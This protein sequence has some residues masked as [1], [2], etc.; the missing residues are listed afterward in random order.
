MACV[1]EEM[2][3]MGLEEELSCPICLELYQDPVSLPC[4][5]NFCRECL[6]IHIQQHRDT[7]TAEGTQFHCPSCRCA[8]NLKDQLI[9]RLPKNCVLANIISRFQSSKPESTDSEAGS[10]HENQGV[11]CQVHRKSLS[12]FCNTCDQALC[13]K[14]LVDH[15]GHHTQDLEDKVMSC[16]DEV[17]QSVLPKITKLKNCLDSTQ[18]DLIVCQNSAEE[19]IINDWQVV[20]DTFSMLRSVLNQKESELNSNLQTR[21][22]DIC[23]YFKTELQKIDSQQD[24]LKQLESR[25]MTVAY[26]PDFN[27]C[28]ELHEEL[29]QLESELYK[30]GPVG[31]WY[32]DDPRTARSKQDICDTLLR[33]TSD[34]DKLDV[35]VNKQSDNS[36]GLE[37]AVQ[38]LNLHSKSKMIPNKTG[39]LQHSNP[40]TSN[41][42]D[43]V[44]PNTEGPKLIHAADEIYRQ[45]EDTEIPIPRSESTVKQPDKKTQRDFL[46]KMVCKSLKKHSEVYIV[47]K[48]WLEKCQTF[49]NKR[50][51][52]GI[53]PGPV[54]NSSIMETGDNLSANLLEGYD[55]V[56]LNESGWSRIVKWYGLKEGQKPIKHKV[57][58]EGLLSEA[59][60]VEIYPMKVVLACAGQRSCQ[61]YSKSD[62]LG[63]LKQE[64][65][66]IF[67]IFDNKN[68]RMKIK[69]GGTSTNFWINLLSESD[70]CSLKDAGITQG[71]EIHCDVE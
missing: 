42:T 28:R 60:S 49:L 57:I 58:S 20:M 9:S 1:I 4:Q 34:L 50:E 12:V 35:S 47:S 63:F 45:A 7:S 8:V 18:Q 48:A 2:A 66:R 21:N 37:S 29:A 69:V 24:S 67:K 22:E 54:D 14:C 41:A 15:Q 51:G 10:R 68:L 61:H 62:S 17:K 39:K 52:D 64:F 33:M 26:Y 65:H 13:T 43:P 56:A 19:E 3:D 5:H 6:N 32:K 59:L 23:S 40:L 11:V 71:T 36:F 55:F 53:N 38:G 70:T 46:K 30:T 27:K 44:K 31:P 25:A 16:K